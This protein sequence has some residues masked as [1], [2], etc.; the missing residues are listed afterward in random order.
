MTT[1]RKALPWGGITKLAKEFNCSGTQITKILDGKVF[2]HPEVL[3]AAERVILESK[4]E[5]AAYEKQKE[6]ILKVS[7]L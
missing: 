7:K 4:A 2:G 3:K 1:L 5:K 6:R